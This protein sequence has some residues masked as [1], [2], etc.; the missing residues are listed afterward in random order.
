MA[1]DAVPH[2]WTNFRLRQ[3]QQQPATNISFDS[4]DDQRPEN[5]LNLGGPGEKKWIG[6][7]T[8][9]PDMGQALG[10]LIY[11]WLT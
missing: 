4:W 2:F 1:S 8:G 5:Y 6:W 7:L 10:G 11:A 3:Q 9:F